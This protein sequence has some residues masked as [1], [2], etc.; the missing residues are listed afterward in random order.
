MITLYGN[1]RLPSNC[2][3]TSAAD[4]GVDVTVVDDETS[5]A[6]LFGALSLFDVDD[7]DLLVTLV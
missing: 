6:A 5:D 3:V 4:V 1:T 2:G 7:R